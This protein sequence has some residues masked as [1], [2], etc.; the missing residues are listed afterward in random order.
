MLVDILIRPLP[1][2]AYHIH[3]SISARSAGV[4][5]DV[6]RLRDGTSL[7]RDGYSLRFPGISPWIEARRIAALRCVLPFPLVWEPL[8]GPLG[9]GTSIL[10]RDPGYRLVGPALRKGAV[11]PVA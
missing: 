1:H 7:H 3:H 2:V 8:A 10:Q 6:V 5:I 9:I 11:V 4:R